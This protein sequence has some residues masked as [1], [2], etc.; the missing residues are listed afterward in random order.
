MTWNDENCSRTHER[1]MGNVLDSA[2]EHYIAVS[3]HYDTMGCY[4]SGVFAMACYGKNLNLLMSATRRRRLR[5]RPFSQS[6]YS[7][8]G[9]GVADH[10]VT[11]TST[12][13]AT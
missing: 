6:L 9:L 11:T 1:Y 13:Q 12:W 2:R 3:V 8:N 5:M 7:L 4:G 10:D